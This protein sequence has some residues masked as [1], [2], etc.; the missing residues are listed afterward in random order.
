MTPTQPLPASSNINYGSL[1]KP[2]VPHRPFSD[3]N[4]LAPED[5]FYAYSPP[6]QRQGE[7]Y[8]SLDAGSTSVDSTSTGIGAS[9]RRRRGKDRGRSA[10][11]RGKG[12][13][14]KLLWVKQKDCT[15]K[16]MSPHVLLYIG[17]MRAN[18]DPDNYTDPPT[19]L[20]HLQRNP[21]LRPYDFWPLVADSTVIVQ[22]ISSVAIFVC[23]F[24]GIYQ[25]RVSPVSVVS[26]GSAGT[27]LGWIMW[28]FWVGHQTTSRVHAEV[29][30]NGDSIN[31]SAHS[32]ASSPT[33]TP[34]PTPSTNSGESSAIG[35]GLSLT[36]SNLSP[37]KGHSHSHSQ[38]SISS[39]P[40]PTLS[41]HPSNPHFRT[42][43]AAPNT[44]PHAQS[45]LATAKS[46]VLI[47]IALL[48]LSPILKSLT[49]STTSD[50]IWAMTFWLMC[51]NIFFFDY[52][53]GV[54]V[55]F[56]ASLSTNAALMASTVLASRLPSTT[57]VFSLTLF[58]I[59][60]FGLFPV[61][62]RHLR[63]TSWRGHLILTFALVVG[64][65]ASLGTA[66]SKK[67]LWEGGWKR[68]L[69]GAIIWG[70]GSSVGMG[71]CSWWLIG[72]Q[73]YKNVVIGPWDPARPVIRGGQWE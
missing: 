66:L 12:V 10:S 68:A 4:H 17:L 27:V 61:F 7:Q 15:L 5:A 58:S 57:H 37:K 33:S 3:P 2:P 50:S 31:G 29:N 20:S 40:S 11:R 70:A 42:Y 14:K 54:G 22:H 49:E 73:R 46:A 59:E 25:Q 23:S 60:V 28:D 36:T 52:S 6:R 24:V 38:T 8:L 43:F 34:A 47:Y 18:T 16:L 21:R 30:H 32:V 13:W 51:I 63:H 62:R 26:W 69:A 65:G 48:G 35:L 71:G 41:H 72:L 53:G 1:K 39:G 64:A 44:T 56:P 45:R 55:K 9:T 19:F 67:A